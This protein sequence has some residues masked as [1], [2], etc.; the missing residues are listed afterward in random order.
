MMKKINFLFSF[1]LILFLSNCRSEDLSEKDNLPGLLGKF[2][3]RK[4]LP[5]EFQK[6]DGLNEKFGKSEK[7]LAQKLSTG[8]NIMD[9]AV[10]DSA[11]ALEATDGNIV[12]Y[13]FP[14][15]RSNQK[16]Y[17]ENLVLQK[18][19]GEHN[20]KSLLY[21]YQRIGAS[22]YNTQNIEVYNL[23]T[24]TSSVVGKIKY[25]TVSSAT[26]CFEFQTTSA[27]CGFKGHH[28]NGQYCPQSGSYMPYD[29]VTVFDNCPQSG[30][31][32]SGGDGTP[33]NNNPSPG[34]GGGNYGATI[35]IPNY[36]RWGICSERTGAHWDAFGLNSDQLAF[37]NGYAQNALRGE[38]VSFLGNNEVF[39]FD[40]DA[41]RTISPEVKSVGLWI[42]NSAMTNPDFLNSEFWADFVN[43]NLQVQLAAISYLSQNNLSW[44]QAEQTISSIITFVNENPDT[45]DIPNI[46]NRVQALD[47]AL[48]QNPNLLLDI[49]CGELSKWQELATHPVPV[50]IK[51]R[52]FQI[53]GLTHWYQD[54]FAIQNL[55]FA[56]GPG[57]N[58]DLFSVR[59]T[60]MPFKPGTNEK[61]TPAE[62]FDFFRRNINLFAESFTPIVNSSNG[63]DDTTLWFSNNPL[64][65]LIHIEIPGDNGTV[66]CSG[67]SIQA[68]IFTTIKA[69]ITLDGLHPVSGN[70]LFG[71][72]VDSNGFMYLYTRGVDRFT[73]PIGNS[74]LA[75]LAENFAFLKADELWK[76]MQTKLENYIKS[77]NGSLHN[78]VKT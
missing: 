14:V 13:T 77:I 67:Y 75:Y 71:Y 17:F 52:L 73:K 66:E 25:T 6:I 23:D 50:S 74:T 22:K 62:F 59:I 47:N 55:D 58:M 2:T 76:S 31:G 72:F 54:D 10:I 57:L 39:T 38:M 37:I 1:L 41:P 69:P 35:P 33:G 49:P 40:C 30:G 9:G 18:K 26:G 12:S 65:A 68:W 61:Y 63:I 78:Q 28:T 24:I 29:Y 34:G 51:N 42:I 8:K 32:G 11:Y 21:R 36:P 46:F 56:S 64:G 5:S 53:N 3:S 19:V 45:D 16:G 4:I 70:R 27:D 7:F 20:F 15:Y 60:N 48:T 44:S 43:G